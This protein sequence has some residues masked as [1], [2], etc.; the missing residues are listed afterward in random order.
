MKEFTRNLRPVHS[1]VGITRRL[2]IPI[3][4]PPIETNLQ[5]LIKS[6][7]DAHKTNGTESSGVGRRIEM[8]AN[9]YEHPLEVD[10][11]DEKDVV[12]KIYN[13]EVV[14]K[15]RRRSSSLGSVEDIRN[16]R[17]HI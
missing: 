14:P 10:T 12:I 2:N 3:R 4:I 13:P 1:A 9:N 6:V 8:A 11:G 15:Q 16:V 7:D 5:A 17:I